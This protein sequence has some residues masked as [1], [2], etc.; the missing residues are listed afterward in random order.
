[1][2]GYYKARMMARNQHHHPGRQWNRLVGE[3]LSMLLLPLSFPT[4]FSKWTVIVLHRIHLL[5]AQTPT[6]VF[7]IP[8]PLQPIVE[9]VL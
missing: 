4:I 1:M 3:L 8:N 5:Y 2:L 6:A 9:T 7:E